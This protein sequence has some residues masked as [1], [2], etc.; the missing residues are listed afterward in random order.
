MFLEKGS[1]TT[2]PVNY[3]EWTPLPKQ[4][5]KSGDRL[6]EVRKKVSVRN[7]KAIP[8]GGTET[9]EGRR[10][11]WLTWDPV[12]QTA[13]LLPLGKSEYRGRK[14]VEPLGAKGILV[15]QEPVRAGKNSLVIK[16]DLSRGRL[17]EVEK[18]GEVEGRV[19]DR[20]VFPMISGRNIRRYGLN[21]V[22]YIL[23]PHENRK[24]VHNAVPESTMKV[25]YTDTYAWLL[26][27]RKILEDTKARNSKFYRKGIDPFYE[28]D[29]V[30]PYTFAP[31][32]VAWIEQNTQMIACVVSTA[33]AGPLAGKL[34]I[35]DSK[36]TI[37]PNRNRNRSALPL[38]HFEFANRRRT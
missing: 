28:R 14:G 10:S 25:D 6:S 24:G 4:S 38:R 13:I 26:K 30:G 20:F 11:P 37:R 23:L 15:L 17:P 7:L 2:Y 36:V 22:T 5:A 9:D 19:E 21:G 12:K 32:K 3:E 18:V 27:W 33:P 16:N 29:N 8:V 1:E 35:P 31:F 34:V